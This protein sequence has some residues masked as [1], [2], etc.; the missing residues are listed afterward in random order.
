MLRAWQRLRR[1]GLRRSALRAEEPLDG[2][3][4]VCVWRWQLG[5]GMLHLQ[6]TTQL[7]PLYCSTV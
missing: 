5:G 6:P 2:S 7:L 4:G 1:D 3:E